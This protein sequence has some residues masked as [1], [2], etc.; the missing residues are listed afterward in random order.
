MDFRKTFV[1]RDLKTIEKCWVYLSEKEK[2]FITYFKN[3]AEPEPKDFNRLQE[4]AGKYK[5]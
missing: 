5:K 2:D 4:I 3:Q 1:N